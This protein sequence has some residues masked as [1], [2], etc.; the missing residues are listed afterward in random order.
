MLD[1][2]GELTGGGF[3]I[4][5]AVMLEQYLIVEMYSKELTE[6]LVFSSEKVQHAIGY[7]EEHFPDLPIERQTFAC[8]NGIT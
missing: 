1:R 8:V 3:I 2:I 6:L 5:R 7:L 4:N